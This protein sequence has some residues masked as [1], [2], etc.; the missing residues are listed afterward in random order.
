MYTFMNK[1]KRIN[2][3]IRQTTT[4]GFVRRNPADRVR[5]GGRSGGFSPQ[6]GS[7]KQFSQPDGFTANP[8]KSNSQIPDGTQLG[9]K[10]VTK[11]DIDMTLDP[12]RPKKRRKFFSKPRT[13]KEM[14]KRVAVGTMALVLFVGLALLGL[15][16][17][18]A[19]QVLDGG[20]SALALNCDVDPRLL[21][22]EGDGRVNILLLGKGGPGHDGP[23]LTDTLLVASV[24]SCQKEVGLLS[25]PRD[26]YVEMPG[27]G[28]MKINSIYP[29]AKENAL[30]SGKSKKQA[31]KI[32]INATEKVVENVTDM[33]I[34]YYGMVDFT[35]FQKAID[36]VGGVDVDVKEQLYDPSVAWENDWNPVIAE[37]GKQHFDGKK[38]LLYSRSRYGSARGDFDRTERQREVMVALKDKIFSLGTFSNPLKITGL[39]NAFGSH[40]HTDLSIDDML[41]LY[42]IIGEVSNDKVES[43]GLADPPQ[44]LV[45]TDTVGGLSVVIP[46]AGINNYS[47]IHRYLRTKLRDGF[48]KKEDASIAVFNGTGEAGKAKEYAKML[49]S[50]GYKVTQV[51]DVSSAGSGIQLYD[52]KNGENKYTRQYLELRT[53]SNTEERIPDGINVDKE[54]IDFVIIIGK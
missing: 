26:L 32:A 39:L 14:F 27:N 6:L 15:L 19:S 18:R 38:A 50:Y 42:G 17:W 12:S 23:D 29:T 51:G 16:W 9:R 8:R 28:S 53:K 49:K 44:E 3:G 46:S 2:S 22:K 5:S 21:E 54:K 13:K 11:Q 35:A 37:K 4:D 24:D 31:E 48:L 52:L 7:K 36:T 20:E 34:H 41:K 30:A 43:V 10:P 25:I 1:F 40:V 47:E 45:T 33:P